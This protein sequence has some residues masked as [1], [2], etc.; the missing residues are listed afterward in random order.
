MRVMIFSVEKNAFWLASCTGYTNATHDRGVWEI[1]EI[2][3]TLDAIVSD[4]SHLNLELLPEDAQIG[5]LI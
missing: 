3:T 4:I 2:P 1:A 5:I